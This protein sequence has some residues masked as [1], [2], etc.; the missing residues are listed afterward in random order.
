[1]TEED[2]TKAVKKLD[3]KFDNHVEIR[4]HKAKKAILPQLDAIIKVNLNLNA[5]CDELSTKYE[6]QKS[7]LTD[8]VQEQIPSLSAVTDDEDDEDDED[9]DES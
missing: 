7:A 5:I 9:D 3:S 1:M 4:F 8:W 6:I 2:K